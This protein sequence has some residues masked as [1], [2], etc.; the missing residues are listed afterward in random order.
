MHNTKGLLAIIASV[1]LTLALLLPLSITGANGP[2][3]TVS[4]VAPPSVP[5][6][7]TFVAN[8]TVSYVGNFDSCGFDVTYNQAI[9]HVTD[10]TGGEIDGHAIVVGAGN[11][12][13]IPAGSVD[14]GRIRVI[15]TKSGAPGCGLNGTGYLAQIHFTAVGSGSTSS[16]INLEGV[17]MYD[18]NAVKI[19]TP[20]P[21]GTS[22]SL[23]G[24]TPT[25]AVGGPAHRPSKLLILIPWIAIGAAIIVATSLLVRRRRN[26][27]R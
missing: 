18:C 25:G 1:G 3:V 6:G 8:V 10:V 19:T 22:V 5:A 17:G 4:I 21:Q 14:T 13:Y 12:T 27:M 7:S 16:N 26:A 20:T 15:A 2:T 9:I 11:W 24:P 23:S